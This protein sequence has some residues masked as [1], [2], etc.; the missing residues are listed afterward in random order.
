SFRA[1]TTTALRQ[2]SDYLTT[3]RFDESAVQERKAHYARLHNARRERLLQSEKS[4]SEV[5]TP[6]HLTSAIRRHADADTIIV[7][8]GVT[9]YITI[10]NHLALSRPGG[11]FVSGGG[12]LGY[13]GGGSI[14][15]KL[16][17]PDKTIICLIGD[18][19]YLFSV[20]SSVHWMARR[21][22]TP[23]LQIIYN[24]G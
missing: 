22:E 21:Y 13:G 9:N 15:V 6:A 4:E 20:P 24:N 14:G 2:F 3:S 10:I 1:D 19:S 23:F 12:A 11:M 16:G 5:I 7:N 17:C 18:G 8:E